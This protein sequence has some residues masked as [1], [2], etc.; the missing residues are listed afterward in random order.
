MKHLILCILLCSC[1]QIKGGISDIM[2]KKGAEGEPAPRPAN[3]VYFEKYGEEFEA[4]AAR[5]G[6]HVKANVPVSFKN[7]A[8]PQVMGLCWRWKAYDSEHTVRWIEISA[9]HWE[10]LDEN[11]R[12][13]LLD[14]EYGHCV[15]GRGHD[16]RTKN[17]I[18][19]SIMNEYE[20]NIKH[21]AAIKD[22]YE[23]EL[24]ENNNAVESIITALNI[25]DMELADLATEE[26]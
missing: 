21:F 6:V 12:Q 10:R 4:M 19:L 3:D 24:V 8:D 7:I 11:G 14:H 5:Y 9:T 1:G 22:S 17:G 20:G 25:S 26:K 18:H 15:L 16:N 2:H 23:E 13:A